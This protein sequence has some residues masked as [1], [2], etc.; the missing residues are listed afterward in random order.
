MR[1]RIAA[2]A[3]TCFYATARADNRVVSNPANAATDDHRFGLIAS[4]TPVV[5]VPPPTAPVPT[6]TA[7]AGDGPTPTPVPIPSP[8]NSPVPPPVVVAPLRPFVATIVDSKWNSS[9]PVITRTP[10]RAFPVRLTN[11]S[12]RGFITRSS[13][14]TG[15]AVIVGN[16]ALP[17]LV[18]TVGA[19]LPDFG[20]P[21]AL[22]TPLLSLYRG[23]ELAAQ[24]NY[25][26]PNASSAA[27]YLGAFPT[28]NFGDSFMS[29]AAL[30][31]MPTAG[32]LSARCDTDTVFEGVGL[33]EF[34]DGS[35]TPSASSPR[36]LNF[37]ARGRVETGDNALIV[38]FVVAGDGQITLLLRGVGPTLSQFGVTNTLVDPQI[39]LYANASKITA[40]D[41]WR[42]ESRGS[43][44]LSDTATQVGAFALSDPNESAMIV[45]LAA[46]TYSLT[47]RGAN[48]GTGEALAEIYEVANSQ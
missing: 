6:L 8:P 13:S 34:Y 23:S 47:L 3:L 15:G 18:R 30:V 40:S 20:V 43:T 28:K 48:N 4:E 29:D 36:F 12:A 16:G 38:G 27:T 46:G 37:S 26:L 1:L 39:E 24:T 5:P 35:P 25:G 19:T 11:I 7:G 44:V 2:V 45:K 21:N 10:S 42:A 9:A 22:L 31:G 33:V 17:V 41:N 32:N 14:L